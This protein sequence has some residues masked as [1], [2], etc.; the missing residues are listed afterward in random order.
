MTSICS[1]FKRHRIIV[2]MT[3]SQIEKYSLAKLKEKE[4]FTFTGN[5]KLDLSE[6][7]RK[8]VTFLHDKGICHGQLREDY[9]IIEEV[10][11]YLFIS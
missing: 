3:T 9:V 5:N 6:D 8:A 1:E 4:S 2:A 7:I 11:I 10:Y